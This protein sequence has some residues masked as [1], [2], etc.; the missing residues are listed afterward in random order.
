ML[1]Q[2]Q[3]KAGTISTFGCKFHLVLIFILFSWKQWIPGRHCQIVMDFYAADANCY[4]V[5]NSVKTIPDVGLLMIIF[6]CSQESMLALGLSREK[7][8]N[9]RS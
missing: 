8:I 1:G 4:S 6:S 3:H 2:V 5:V 9:L 7:Q